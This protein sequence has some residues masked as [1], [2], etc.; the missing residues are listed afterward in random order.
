V[1]LALRIVE[2]FTCALA[3]VS[4]AGL[5]SAAATGGSK[6]RTPTLLG[7]YFAGAGIGITASA[8]VVPPLLG[9]VGWRGGWLVLGALTLVAAARSR[10]L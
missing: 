4:G 8:L 1:L 10:T 3:F 2:G 9:T 6:S 5:T 7:L